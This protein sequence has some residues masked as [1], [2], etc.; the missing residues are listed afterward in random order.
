MDSP[1]TAVNGSGEALT[2]VARAPQG[3]RARKPKSRAR[4]KVASLNIR[5]FGV[6]NN[7]DGSSK[8]MLVNQL[9]RDQRIAILA[10]QE[11]HLNDERANLLNTVF[12]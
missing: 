12:E 3:S 1:P 4:I 11:T 2:E 5:G 7:I 9:V 6:E 8:W 10:L